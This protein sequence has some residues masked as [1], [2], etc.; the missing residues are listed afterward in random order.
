[1]GMLVDAAENSLLNLLFR[2]VDYTG[3]GDAGG[4]RGSVTAGSLFISGSTAWP[5]E[6]AAQNTNEPSYAG[7]AR[8]SVARSTGAWSAPSGGTLSPAAAISLG[9]K[10]DVGTVTIP[11]W[12]LGQSSSGAGTAIAWGVFG[13]AT[14]GV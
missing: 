11:F 1:M 5:G 13:N 2:N 6:S 4:L 9:T 3:V 14:F 7:Y 12:I 10:T 8:A